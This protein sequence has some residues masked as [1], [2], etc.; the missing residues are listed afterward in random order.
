MLLVLI[1]A[2]FLP[3]DDFILDINFIDVVFFDNIVERLH[4]CS[5]AV[6]DTFKL[7]AVVIDFVCLA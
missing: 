2:D 6:V 3:F 1:L 7:A 5:S 4:F